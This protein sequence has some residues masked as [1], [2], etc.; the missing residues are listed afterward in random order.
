[1]IKRY[2]IQNILKGLKN[3]PAVGLLGPR[4][5]GKTTLAKMIQ[6]EFPG[7][8][9][10][11][12]ERP[13]DLR[14][15]TEPELYLRDKQEYLVILDEIQLSPDLFPVLRS[16]IDEHRVPGRFLVL[17]SA[18]PEL[19][20]QSS[21]S[22]AGR[23]LFRELTPFQWMELNELPLAQ[24]DHWIRGGFYDSLFAGDAEYSY[25]WRENFLRTY[26]ERDIPEFGV[27]VDG[28][29]LK[30]FIRILAHYQGELMNWNKLA[31][32]AGVSV[33]TAKHYVALLQNSYLIRVLEPLNA[34]LKKRLVKSPKVYFRDSGLL[35][36]LLEIENSEAL[37]GHSVIGAS[38]EG[39]A[40]ENILFT[41]P[42]ER[43]NFFRT[44]AGAELDLI[45]ERKESRIAVEFKRSVS[46]KVTK[47]FHHACQDLSID[48]A[49]VIAPVEE[50]YPLN[51]FTMVG[52]IGHF[53][54]WY[55]RTNN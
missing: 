12:L 27:K 8:F 53:A 35:H 32:S 2:L 3:S 46:P 52:N 26:V 11:D 44:Q 19:I 30:R 39:Y 9:Y 33:P 51:E 41:A 25:L 22:L 24:I 34:N 28:V 37:F 13:S 50:S 29:A 6:K 10:L 7:A 1:M 38:W 36:A 43:A 16:L 21:E 17:G 49:W 31:E 20:R 45:L 55:R 14:K 4:Q 42:P 54:S 40:L 48:S 15:L 23:I 47:G 5:C 18:S